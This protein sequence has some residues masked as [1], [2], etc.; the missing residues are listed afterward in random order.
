MTE[1]NRKIDRWYHRLYLLVWL[2]FFPFHP[3]KVVGSENIPEGA[4]LVCPNHTGLSD[5]FYVVFAFRR[6][7][8]LRIMAKAELMR[9]P[10]IGPL[11]SLVGVFGVERGNADVGAIKTAMKYLRSDHKVLMFP[12]GTRV[13]EGQ[14]V[15]AKT[16]AA[17]LAVR[18]NCPIV[19]VYVPGKKRWF[20]SNTVRIGAP[21]YPKVE[22]KKATAEEYRAIA[23]EQMARVEELRIQAMG[24]QA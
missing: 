22:G 6:K 16:G 1:E 7:H 15:E 23:E 18:T 13:E 2:F 12:E 3:V 5:P 14:H 21:L 24:E 10:V 9:V 20:R 17:M 4:A 19:P 11:L 8:P